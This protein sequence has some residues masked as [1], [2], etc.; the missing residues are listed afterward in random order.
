MRSVTS[1]VA[2]VFVGMV[3]DFVAGGDLVL[4][5]RP[6]GLKRTEKPVL[7]LPIG[8]A[9]PKLDGKL[10]EPLWQKAAVV[11]KW[12]EY[13]TMVETG[14]PAEV[15]LVTDGSH[16]YLGF[17]VTIADMSK[18]N[19][20]PPK[21]G[22]D[23]YGGSLLEIF[24]DPGATG[25]RKYQFCTNPLGLRYDG[26]DDAKAWNGAWR[27]VGHVGE[28]GWAMEVAIPVKDFDPASI[29][30]GSRWSA[31]FAF[32]DAEEG[33]H[34][35]TGK[36]GAPGADYATVFFGTKEQFAATIRPQLS[37]W[38]D[39]EVYDVRD[40]T[41]VALARLRGV[42]AGH[43][44]FALRLRVLAGDREVQSQTLSSLPSADLDLTLDLRALA[45]GSYK[46]TAELL[47]GAN[48]IA[49]ASV[50]FHKEKRKLLPEGPKQGKVALQ[51]WPE[52]NA[53]SAAWPISTGV[54]FAQ[55]A[56][57]SADNV[58]LIGPDGKEVPC[59]T[60]IRSRWNRRG[61]IQWLGV[62]FVP[63]L[64]AQSPR[65]WLEYGPEVKRAASS[66][67][68][69]D[70][71]AQQIT[72][73]TDK[74]RFTVNRRQFKLIDSLQYDANGNGQ[75]EAAEQILAAGQDAGPYLVDHEGKRYD[76]ALDDKA[77]VIIE[78]RGPVKVT[79][80]AT[81]WY[82]K[83]GT[84]GK[85]TSC[86]LPTDRLCQFRIRISA[87]AGVPLLRFAVS[88]VVTYDSDKVRLRDL[89]LVFPMKGA[90]QAQIGLERAA[91]LTWSQQRLAANP[92]L[93][94][95]RWDESIEDTWRAHPRAS[96]WIDVATPTAY[97]TV[98]M[99]NF[100]RL[101]PKE[102]EFRDG[103][104]VLHI[105]PGHGREDTFGLY[106]QLKRENIYRLWYA[107][108]GRELDFKFPDSY[109]QS[110][111]EECKRTKAFG[112]YY[113]ATKYANA[114]GLC[115][116]N[117][118]VM[119][120]APR[121]DAPSKRGPT[122]SY[123][124]D[125]DPHAAPDPAYTCGTGVFG[126]MLHAD[127]QSF[128][129]LET[130]LEKGFESLS[131]RTLVNNEY[132]QFIFGGEHT[133]WYYWKTP[134]HAGIHRVWITGHYQI[135]RMPLVQYARTGNPLYLRWGRTFG[136]SLRDISIVHYVSEE[137]RFK[138][139][140]LGAMY[141][142]KGF[143]PWGGD[144]HVAAHPTSMDFLAYDYYLTGN[145]RSRDV[146]LE[147]VEGLKI[148][149]P[150]GHGTREGIQPLADMVVAYRLTW[151]AALVELM[152]RF[153]QA[154]FERAPL[155][156][157][158]WWDY[159][160]LLL[161]RYYGLTGAEKAVKE[162]RELRTARG[163]YGG[164]ARH[165]DGYLSLLDGKMD[166]LKEWCPVLY[167]DSISYVDQPRIYATGHASHVWIRYVYYAHKAPYLLK[168]MKEAGLTP[169]RPLTTIPTVLP[170]L[171]RKTWVVVRE[172]QDRAI[173][174]KLAFSRGPSGKVRVRVHRSEGS[175]LLEQELVPKKGDKELA[176]TIPADGK[177][178]DYLISIELTGAYDSVLW[179]ITD[180]RKEMALLRPGR[181]VFQPSG[182]GAR[183][184]LAPGK[185]APKTVTISSDTKTAMG[186]E[187]LDAN[188]AVIA[189]ASDSRYVGNPQTLTIPSDRPAPLSIYLSSHTQ[190][191]VAGDKILAVGLTP[192]A[193]FAPKIVQEP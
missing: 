21:K 10:D 130:M 89:A 78:E 110:L 64:A 53:A 172:K 157:Q 162:Y 5:A 40:V 24:F 188:Q 143:V 190:L 85:R 161:M 153:A 66:K 116:H 106:D 87:Y 154:I 38:L 43:E 81:G 13:Q 112:G 29:Q 58:R 187:L 49:A 93:L 191:T 158:G 170:I 94:Q 6:A 122:L 167:A 123:L 37:L 185:D 147:W 151:D 160:P 169:Q 91:P 47:R 72:I 193:L 1:C 129:Q 45:V 32:V 18:A 65:Y 179:P 83:R 79:V 95:H 165:I 99:R 134:P 48:Q 67:I 27:S 71:T 173:P 96:G 115:I 11:D 20:R 178:E 57:W 98:A 102:I 84:Q 3:A 4:D 62:D 12:R 131:S 132:G 163:G 125:E 23:E 114:Q 22:G 31:N 73:T 174:L 41:A 70:E 164:G 148:A 60:E 68:R 144:A 156:E 16:L 33:M 159:H 176:L 128:G 103:A 74:L 127:M 97:A 184:Y 113:T 189:R 17:A 141:H 86:E 80:L 88:T 50:P 166:S 171:D 177:A 52:P 168:A 76:A 51:V 111:D 9:K 15:R 139:H 145:R 137:R 46:L 56:L 107:H 142:C 138:Y 59:Q 155:G 36:W 124:A 100:W 149:S 182:A 109:Y 117:D 180:L 152:D 42:T 135:A 8:Q 34:S 133:Y 7:F 126:P 77:E 54:P 121:K 118:L 186:L 2:L 30:P 39:R 120:F 183:Y 55:D 61:S 136:A 104:L 105:W 19:L 175:K 82:V 101:F 63:T 14:L 181:S 140:Q 75:F 28:N 119:S 146:M 35:W 25:K 150:G 90:E 92:Y 26:R 192:D 108:Q 44:A 69:C